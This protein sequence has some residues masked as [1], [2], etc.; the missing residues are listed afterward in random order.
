MS[1]REIACSRKKEGVVKNAIARVFKKAS[2]ISLILFL[3]LPAAAQEELTYQLPPKAIADIVDAPGNPFII[4]S[5][6]AGMLLVVERPALISI[7]DLSQPELRLAGLRI[8]PRTNGPSLS[9][10]AF[11]KKVIFKNLKTLKEHALTGLPVDARVSDPEWSPDS[12]WLAFTVT[13]ADGIELWVASANDGKAKCL[14]GP[15]LNGALGYG[16]FQWLPDSRGLLCGLVPEG[17]APLPEKNIVPKGPVVQRNEGKVAP[18]RTYQDLLKD[19]DDEALFAHYATSQLAIVDLAGDVQAVGEPALIAYA[20]PSPDGRYILVNVIQRPFSYL[21]PFSEFPQSFEIWDRDGRLVRKIADI[22]LAEDVPPGNDAVRT[23]PRD[24]AWRGDAAATLFWVEAQDG[25]DPAKEAEVRDKV[26]CLATPFTGDAEA[27]PALTYRLRGISWGTGSLAMLTQFWWKTRQ[28]RV[29][30]FAPDALAKPLQEVFAYSSEDRYGDPGRFATRANAQGR[31]VLLADRSGALY[32]LGRGASTEGDRPFV[33]RFDLA[34]GKKVRLWRSSAPYYESPLLV[35]DAD[36]G[37]VLTSR[38]GRKVQP[39]Y[40]LRDLRGGKP[41]QV[42]FFPHPFPALRDVEKQIVRY[43]RPD[44]V[45][46]SGNLYLPVNWK[47]A[48]GPLPVLMWAYP[49]EF[50]SRAAAGQMQ[51]SPF[52]FIRISAYAT[53]LWITQGYAVLDNPTMPI[54]GEGKQEPN[55]TYIEQLVASA[56]AAVDKLVEMGI[57][58]RARM[59]IGG[60]SYGAFMTANLLAHSRL[61]AAGIARSGAYNRT[62]TPFGFQAEERLIWQAPDTYI[63]MSPF[64][65][66]DKLKDPILLIH[67]QADDNSGTF[68]IQ[69]ERF[70]HALKGNGATVRMVLLPNEAHGYDARESIMHMLWETWTWLEKFVRNKK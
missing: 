53:V 56:Q 18:V 66:A 54:V 62:L 5:P 38:E 7:A 27:G 23:G 42:T 43:Q 31:Q 3:C 29:E 39:N 16:S 20:D 17:R 35:V 37:L 9:R 10:T 61:F 33:D 14:T 8:N 65:Y 44:G 40:F 69:T 52:R 51:D 2:F 46:L 15:R 47:Q 70:Y 30:R 45:E 13:R 28:L 60:H 1:A 63:K 4:P 57:G 49:Q 41:K 25:G 64:M 59:A 11:Y 58:D 26:F 55:D 24:F 48:D 50:K 36:K 19:K 22:P 34:S 6:D 12:A 68:P 21:V 32:L 67:G